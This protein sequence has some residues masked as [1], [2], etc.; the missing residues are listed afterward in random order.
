MTDTYTRDELEAEYPFGDVYKQTD[1]LVEPLTADEWDAWI[2]NQVGRPV[3]HL[4]PGEL[5]KVTGLEG[6]LGLIDC[7]GNG[8]LVPLGD[9]ADEGIVIGA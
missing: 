9:A 3:E 2:A 1:D 7:P 5:G 6:R 4:C 8:L